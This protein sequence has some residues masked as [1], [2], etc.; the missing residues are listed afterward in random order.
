MLF[1]NKAQLHDVEKKFTTCWTKGK[2][3]EI[4]DSIDSI[5]WAIS[6]IRRLVYKTDLISIRG[7][8]LFIRRRRTPDA[9]G[10]YSLRL[11][12]IERRRKNMLDKLT[13]HETRKKVLALEK[14]PCVSFKIHILS[15]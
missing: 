7:D 8:L 12:T 9:Y 4:V 6:V 14:S 10:T 2:T 11:F 15:R 13:K 3:K 5:G 1:C